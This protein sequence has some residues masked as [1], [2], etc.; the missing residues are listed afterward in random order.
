M[1]LIIEIQSISK[2][3]LANPDKEFEPE[4]LGEIVT[5]ILKFQSQYKIITMK[6]DSIIDGL[7]QILNDH[8]ISLPNTNK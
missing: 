7:I 3:V 2:K 6:L 4:E 8:N 1:K 5:K